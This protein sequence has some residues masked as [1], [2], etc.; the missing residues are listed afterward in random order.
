M[1]LGQWMVYGG[2]GGFAL[3]LIGLIIARILFA[4]KGRKL[5]QRFDEEYGV[6]DLR[7]S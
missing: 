2:I 3:G 1:T 5:K 4:V 6:A 7:D